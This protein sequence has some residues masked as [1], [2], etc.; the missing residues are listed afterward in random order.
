VDLDGLRAIA[1]LLVMFSHAGS[2]WG[3][4]G[5]AGVTAFFVLSGFLITGILQAELARSGRIDLVGFYRRRFRRLAPAL[6]VLLAVVL[7]VWILAGGASERVLPIVG[8]LLYVNNWLAVMGMNMEPLPHTWSLAIEEQFYLL[9]PVALIVLGPRRALVVALA[10]A[11]GSAVARVVAEGSFEYFSTVTRADAI[12]VGSAL[13]LAGRRAFPSVV[14]VVGVVGLISISLVE[15]SHDVAIA[16]SIVAA[17]AVVT[18]RLPS[19]GRLAPIGRRAYSLYLWNWPLTLMFGPLG[20]LLTF[21][22][23]ELSYRVAERPFTSSRPSRQPSPS[24]VPVTARVPLAARVRPARPWRARPFVVLAA[25]MLAMVLV[26]SCATASTATPVPSATPA[27]CPATA[28]DA[29][30][31]ILV[32]GDSIAAG[33]G[34]AGTDRWPARLEALLREDLPDRNVMVSNWAQGGS[35]INLLENRVAEM[36]LDAYEVAIV[37]TGLNDTSLMRIDQ[38]APRYVAAI[39]K[40]EDAGVKVVIGTAPPTFEGGVFTDRFA[41]VAEELRDIAGDRPMLDIAKEWQELGVDTAADYYLDVVHQNA[42]GQAVIAALARTVVT[43]VLE[44]P[45]APGGS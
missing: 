34:A 29:A 2:P 24:T 20:F 40:L 44:G 22:V 19:L 43:D 8:S 28:G 18:S 10:L 27:P 25:A 6:V 37:I 42:K 1:V 35:Q 9:W 30:T 15:V 31:C 5:N 16:L 14:G 26:S 4:G 13:A 32:L 17:S 3:N 45:A 23:A 7:P 11:A 41:A 38:W 39:E 12:L 33:E 21:P 36:P